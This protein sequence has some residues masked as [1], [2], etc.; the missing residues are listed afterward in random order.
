M[1]KL[2]TQDLEALNGGIDQRAAATGLMC[3]ATLFLL[4]TPGLQPIAAATGIG[5]A[6]GLYAM[7]S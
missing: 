4:L 7:F 5:C 3:G 1:K 6:T 2:S